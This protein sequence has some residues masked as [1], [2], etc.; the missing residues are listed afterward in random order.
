MQLMILE[1]IAHAR[2]EA[3]YQMYNHINL[4]A[5]YDNFLNSESANLFLGLGIAFSDN[6]LK[7]ILSSGSGSLLK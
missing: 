1:V 4:Y 6:D 2:V 7:T 5:G 3:R